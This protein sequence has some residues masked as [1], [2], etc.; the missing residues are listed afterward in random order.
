MF[1]VDKVEDSGGTSFL[2]FL[3]MKCRP[4]FNPDMLYEALLE[5]RFKGLALEEGKKRKP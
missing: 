4:N 1:C 2:G 3:R 5:T